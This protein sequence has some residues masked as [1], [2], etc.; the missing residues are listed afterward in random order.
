MY[1]ALDRQKPFKLR[2]HYLLISTEKFRLFGFIFLSLIWGITQ[3]SNTKKIILEWKL[4][5]L[6]RRYFFKVCGLIAGWVVELFLIA[7]IF[8][9]P[10]FVK[11]FVNSVSHALNENE[12]LGFFILFFAALFF[13]LKE[14]KMIKDKWHESE[15][16]DKKITYVVLISIFGWASVLILF[17]IIMLKVFSI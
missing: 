9:L 11:L 13:S 4:Q 17:R 10:Q 16:Q 7:N 8:G 5:I 2:G 14:S 1:L 6:E 3:V 12:I 15:F